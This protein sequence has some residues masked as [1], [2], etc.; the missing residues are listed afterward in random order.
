[1]PASAQFP[2]A[3]L[4]TLDGKPVDAATLSNDGKPFVVSF[5]ATWCKPCLRELKA[6]HEVYPDWQDETGMK[7]IAISVDEAQNASKVKPLVDALGF[8]YEVLLDTNSEL[9]NAMGIQSVPHLFIID[10][11]GKIVENRS[12]YTEGSEG[13]IIEKIR[14]LIK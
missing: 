12:G 4:K 11:D 8:E 5:F 2:S 9:K 1:M 7:L 10:G 6:I 14:E 13:H 3:Q